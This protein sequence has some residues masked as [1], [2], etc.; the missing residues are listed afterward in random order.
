M[1]LTS[2]AYAEGGM[3]PDVCS[4]KNADGNGDSPPLAWTNPPAGTLSFAIV[5]TDKSNMLRHSMIYDIPANV[6]SLPAEVDAGFSPADV[7]G[8]HQT[9]NFRNDNEYGGPCPNNTH[10]YELAIYALD[11]ATLPNL[12]QNSTAMSGQA[13][14]LMHDLAKATLTATFTP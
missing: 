12:T 3:I 7:P 5:F 14:V 2:T 10:T 11:V 9:R 4:C 8:A 13:Q 6:L 1:T